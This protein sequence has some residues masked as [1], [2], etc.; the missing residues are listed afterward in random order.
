MNDYMFEHVRIVGVTRLHQ[1]ARA[2]QALHAAGTAVVAGIGRASDAPAGGF[3]GASALVAAMHVRV[4]VRQAAI[5]SMGSA[6]S[7]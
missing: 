6:L 4:I 2:A 3:R 7:G 5:G 1:A